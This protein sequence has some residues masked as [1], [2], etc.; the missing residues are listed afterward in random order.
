MNVSFSSSFFQLNLLSLVAIT[1][2]KS[3]SE[4]EA[5]QG[6]HIVES[7]QYDFCEIKAATEDFSDANKLGQGGF[8]A[9]YKVI[10]HIDSIKTFV[11]CHIIY[12]IFVVRNTYIYTI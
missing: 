6:I 3:L 9:V 8:G 5:A 11:V 2:K 7:L 12:I 4:F 10:K 1:L